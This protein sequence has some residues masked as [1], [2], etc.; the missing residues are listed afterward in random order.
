MSLTG[1]APAMRPKVTPGPWLPAIVLLEK[2]TLSTGKGQCPPGFVARWPDPIMLAVTRRPCPR[3]GRRSSI[4]SGQSDQDEL[5]VAGE[6]AGVVRDVE[7]VVVGV[8]QRP[9]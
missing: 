6:L 1:T 2:K 8:W 4:R 3:H 7:E 9:G 5:A